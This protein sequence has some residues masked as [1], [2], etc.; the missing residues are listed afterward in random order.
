M[1]D[2]CWMSRMTRRHVSIVLWCT[3]CK[4]EVVSTL[5]EH[6]HTFMQQPFPLRTTASCW[7]SS[8]A[9]SLSMTS[10]RAS[11][12]TTWQGT[13]AQF[14]PYRWRQTERLPWRRRGRLI[15]KTG[16]SGFGQLARK[17]QFWRCSRRMRKS[18]PW[19][20]HVMAAW[21]PWRW[22]TLYPFG[23]AGE[24]RVGRTVTRTKQRLRK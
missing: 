17:S 6:Q 23:S 8:T 15:P 10:T 13:Q 3:I 5:P 24:G 22:V 20:S 7:G 16:L 14:T 21:L 12:Y 4:P 11:V 2:I 9:A 18:R 19:P 1:E